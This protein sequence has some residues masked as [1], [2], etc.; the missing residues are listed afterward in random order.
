MINQFSWTLS[1]RTGFHNY[2]LPTTQLGVARIKEKFHCI[3]RNLRV[4]ETSHLLR[5]PNFFPLPESSVES[6]LKPFKIYKEQQ[7]ILQ[8]IYSCTTAL[9]PVNFD[10]ITESGKTLCLKNLKIRL[11]LI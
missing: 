7:Q 3:D 9:E 5:N 8:P 2:C 6:P 10:P 1:N 4:Q 11:K